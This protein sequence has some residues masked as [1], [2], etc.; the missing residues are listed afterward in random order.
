VRPLHAAFS[1]FTDLR[2]WRRWPF[3]LLVIGANSIAACIIVYR[4]E[5]FVTR[6]RRPSGFCRDPDD[7]TYREQEELRIREI[8]GSFGDCGKIRPSACGRHNRAIADGPC[9]V[10][11]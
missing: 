8:A 9:N 5:S 3:S 4:F 6:G 11:L 7:G 2:D 1:V 10:A